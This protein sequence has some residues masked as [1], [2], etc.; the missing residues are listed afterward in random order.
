[1]YNFIKITRYS[2]SSVHKTAA[3]Y[4]NKEEKI[5]WEEKVPV[6]KGAIL[7]WQRAPC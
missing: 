2:V 6:K 3:C 4:N 7:R 1:M 5:Q